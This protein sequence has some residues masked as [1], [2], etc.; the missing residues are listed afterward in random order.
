MCGPLVRGRPRGG[1][2]GTIHDVVR[3]IRF[4]GVAGIPWRGPPALSRIV[5]GKGFTWW[6]AVVC[7][8]G[9]ACA[10]GGVRCSCYCYWGL[11]VALGFLWWPSASTVLSTAPITGGT[12][13][14]RV[15]STRGGRRGT[16]LRSLMRPLPGANLH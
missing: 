13:A 3:I 12:G 9:G 6:K 11:L 7:V 8:A 2:G 15:L 4:G 10:G 5:E 14:C 16:I 1:A